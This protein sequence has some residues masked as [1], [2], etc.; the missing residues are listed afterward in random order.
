MELYLAPQPLRERL[1]Q[2][3]RIDLVGADDTRA[4]DTGTQAAPELAGGSAAA[5]GVAA[6]LREWLNANASQSV[7]IAADSAGRREALIDQLASAELNP[8][9]TE[10][11]Q[12]FTAFEPSPPAALAGG[13][14]ARS[15]ERE[16]LV[17][18]QDSKSAE[19]ADRGG[20]FPLTPALSPNDEAIGGEGAK[21]SLP[22]RLAITCAPLDRGFSLTQPALTVLTER[23][24]VGDRARAERQRRRS[25]ERDPEAI[26]R[27]L[28][29]LEIGAPIVHVDHGVGRYLGLV[30]LDVG[31]MPGEFLAIEYARGDKLYVPVAQLAL[32]SR[33]SGADDEHAPLHSLGGESW[34]R[35]KRKAAEKVRDVAAE[36]LAIHAQRAA[37]QG[38]AI[39]F[40][41]ALVAR[42][43]EGFPFEETPD[44]E[45]AIDAV[46]ADLAAPQPMDRVVCG[47]VG[48]GK[49]E[50]ALRAAV[51]A[52]SAGK[53][54]AVLVPTTL[55]AQQHFD[56]FRDRLADFPVRVELL[57][58][59]RAKKEAAEALQRLAEG[60]LDIVV[61]T[62][63]LLQPD[64][65]FKDLGLVIVDE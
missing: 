46:L 59:F 61:G 2:A 60:K 56:N 65:K 49:T 62:H 50:V 55:L 44:Q 43:A 17:R 35:A 9:I 41:R 31:G 26:L 28:T 40:D 63:K 36:L 37:R 12:S 24:L 27:D 3:L 21:G 29:E 19:A 54:V 45:A 4:A 53:Q 20:A 13:E 38:K 11:W 25:A 51:A 47:D 39:E 10:S 52:A 8:E 33:Y 1:N 16:A 30:A 15:A 58:R 18:G 32:V 42:F 57:S 48:F 5:G 6:R 34:E 23:E 64:V 22:L 7:L 14:A